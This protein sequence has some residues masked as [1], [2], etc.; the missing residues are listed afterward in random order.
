MLLLRILLAKKMTAPL[1]DRCLSTIALRFCLSILTKALSYLR[2]TYWHYNSYHICHKVR[3]YILKDMTLE[4][5]E[6]THKT[7]TDEV[8]AV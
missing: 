8:S 5:K 3:K 7:E 4:S 1:L 2:Q 6:H